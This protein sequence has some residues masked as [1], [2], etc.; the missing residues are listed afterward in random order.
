[1]PRDPDAILS[2]KMCEENS[3]SSYSP[4]HPLKEELYDHIEEE[5][6]GEDVGSI[7]L[8]GTGKNPN[9]AKEI[10]DTLKKMDMDN[11][12]LEAIDPELTPKKKYDFDVFTTTYQKHYG[13]NGE[14]SK[15]SD[16]ARHVCEDLEP[17]FIGIQLCKHNDENGGIEEVGRIL[18]EGGYEV[19]KIS[20]QPRSLVGYRN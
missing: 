1:L 16:L 12:N 9:Y 5:F 11:L 19:E 18:S 6:D 20:S 3:H 14:G 15:G 8:I 7:A 2:I 4:N 10:T 17:G 13:L